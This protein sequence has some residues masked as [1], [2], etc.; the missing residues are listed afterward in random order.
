[1]NAHTTP[2][3]IVTEQERTR[4]LHALMTLAE[5]HAAGTIPSQEAQHKAQTL[6]A[7][8]RRRARR[9]ARLLAGSATRQ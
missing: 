7:P 9:A 8:I 3:Y 2:T 1:M 6:I 5:A 4:I